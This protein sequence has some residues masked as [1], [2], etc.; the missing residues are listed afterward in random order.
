MAGAAGR[1]RRVAIFAFGGAGA[2][3]QFGIF[4]MGEDQSIEGG[5]IGHGPAQ[6]PRIGDRAVAVREGNGAG[7][8]EKPDLGHGLAEQ[9]LGQGGAVGSTRT[10]AVAAARRRRKSTSDGSSIT[11][12]VLGITIMEVTPPAAAAWLADSRLSRC[13]AP[14]SPVKT[15]AVDQAR[16]Q[17]QAAAVDHFRIMGFGVVEQARADIGDA[18]ILHQQVRPWRPIRWR[19]RSVAHS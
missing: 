12:S 18:A 2:F 13:S 6:H 14:G 17:H 9:A 1:P 10:R 4:G 11:G 3:H 19:D 7:F 5:G 8:L 15:R 16:R